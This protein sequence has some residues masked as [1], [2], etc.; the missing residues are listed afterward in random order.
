MKII[1]FVKNVNSGNIWLIP[2]ENFLTESEFNDCSHLFTE[3]GIK[4]INDLFS[5]YKNNDLERLIMSLE[6]DSERKN[7]LLIHVKI[8]FERIDKFVK[9]KKLFLWTGIGVI[10]L[11]IPFVVINSYGKYDHSIKT[12]KDINNSFVI[13]FKIVL[14]IIYLII[15]LVLYK[16]K[17]R[18]IFINVL[19]LL[20]I[21][22]FIIQLM[23]FPS[24]ISVNEIFQELKI[25]IYPTIGLIGSTVINFIIIRELFKSRK[26][27]IS[28]MKNVVDLKY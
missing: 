3:K 26:I 1:R 15:F 19:A 13:P 22:I 23:S 8:E 4:I 9:F 27:I 24:I 6:L 20:I 11:I 10:L 28:E 18:L 2:I 16:L 12:L 21:F 5:V 17:T 25:T 7:E 14:F